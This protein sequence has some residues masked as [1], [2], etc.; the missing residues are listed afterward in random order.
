[1]A[2]RANIKI[3]LITAALL[4]G[5][6]V[7]TTP[8]DTIYVNADGTGDY[9]TIQAA[10]DA[11]T[12]GDEVVL[13]PGTYTGNGNRDLDFANALPEGQT[14]AITV[15][16]TD[17]NN[18]DVVE[19]TIINCEGTPNEPHRGFD[20]H[21]GE[22]AN[23]IISGLTITKGYS[24]EFGGGIKCVSSSPTIINCN[25]VANI[26]PDGG[27]GLSNHDSSPSLINCVFRENE[28]HWGGG[29]C[30]LGQS[31][32]TIANCT[33]SNNIGGD[34]AGVYDH[35]IGYCIL[36]NC[37]FN[38]NSGIG[39]Y[40]HGGSPK[41]TKCSFTNNS[42]TAIV[43][44]GGSPILSDCIFTDNQ[45]HGMYNYGGS[46]VLTSC[47]FIGNS[48]WR[49][50]GMYNTSH[51]SPLL[52][53][54]VFLGNSATHEGG[55]IYNYEST[56]ILNNCTFEDNSAEKGGGVY[57]G[58]HP[59]LTNCNFTNNSADEGGGMYGGYHPLLTNCNFAA[60]KAEYD[61]GGMYNHGGSPIFTN[62]L[63]TGNWAVETG[64][65]MCNV[66]SD[67]ILT[68]CTFVS[69]KAGE[70]GGL[71][72]WSSDPVL[73]NCIIAGNIDDSGTGETAQVSSY[74]YNCQPVIH[75]CCIT[76]WSHGGVGNIAADPLFLDPGYW[77]DNGT[78]DDIWDDVWYEGNYHIR[79]DSPCIDAGDPNFIDDPNLYDMDGEP[80]VIAGRVDIG[81][82]EHN[83]QIPYLTV[84]ST[85]L[86]YYSFIEE[87]G[88]SSQTL[89]L[90]NTGIGTLQWEIIGGSS[91][92]SI[93]N[94]SGTLVGDT[95]QDIFVSVDTTNLPVGDYTGSLVVRNLQVPYNQYQFQITLRV[96]HLLR[97]PEDYTT[98]QAAID[99]AEDGDTVLVANRTY[100]G[101]GNRD[102][103]FGGKLIILRS[104][105]GPQSCIIDC[106]GSADE[107]HRGFIFH[108][109]EDERATLEGFTITNG[110]ASYGG[111]VLCENANPTVTNCIFIENHSKYN[112]GGALYYE[113]WFHSIS[114]KSIILTNCTFKNNSAE[115]GGGICNYNGNIKLINCSFT[116]NFAGSGGGICHNGEGNMTLMNCIFSGNSAYDG[117]G[118]LSNGPGSSTLT[119]CIFKGNAA[120][121][122]GGGMD[123]YA[124]AILSN[125]L[126]TGNTAGY[127]GGGLSNY[128]GEYVTATN[129]TFVGNSLQESD[130][131]WWGWGAAG[132]ESIGHET[133]LT[134]CILWN[135]INRN[136]PVFE[137]QISNWGGWDSNINYCCIQGWDDLEWFLKGGVGNIGTEPN[138][139][140]PG[141]WDPNGTP[142]NYN[143]DEWIEGDYRLFPGSACI[144][145]GTDAGLYTD[146]EGN[147]RPLDG[148]NDG[149]ASADMGAYEALPADRALIMLSSKELEFF[150]DEGGEN[151]DA[152]TLAIW[153]GGPDI[154][155][156]TAIFDD[157]DWLEVNPA[158][159]SSTGQQNQITLSAGT[160]GMTW[161]QYNCQIEISDPCAMFSPVIVRVTLWVNIE[162]HVPA[163]FPT[164]QAAINAA[165]NGDRIIVADDVYTGDGNRDIDFRGK[166]ITLRSANGPAGCIINC[167]S[168]PSDPNHWYRG[169]NFHTAEGH[170]S[171]LDGFTIINGMAPQERI[172]EVIQIGLGQAITWYYVHRGGA[173]VC[174]RS[175]PTIHNCT[176]RGNGTESGGGGLHISSGSPR[177][178]NCRFAYNK[179][180]CGAGVYCTK[181]SPTLTNCHFINNVAQ[182][183][184]NIVEILQG[185]NVIQYTT[186]SCAGLYNSNST[187]T[188]ANCVFAGNVAMSP[189]VGGI[190]NQDST[191][192]I[193]N[194]T[195]VGNSG[196]YANT[197]GSEL[198]A[199]EFLGG[200]PSNI[201][202]ANSIL[203]DGVEEIYNDDGSTISI[204]YSDIDGGWPGE[205]NID[206]DPCFLDYGYWDDK[207]TPTDPNDDLWINGDYHLKWFSPCVNAGD[208]NRE[209]T[210]QTD[211]D[212]LQRVCLGR[213]DIGA[214]EVCAIAYWKMDEDAYDDIVR[215]SSGNYNNGTTQ[216]ITSV[217]H[218]E[219]IINGALTFNGID[220]YIQIADS[221]SLSPTQEVTVCGW[222]WFNDA[223]ENVGL[224]WKHNYNFALWTVS[225]TVRFA[226]WN[227]L[228]EGSTATFSTSLLETGW[229]FIAGVFDGT[230]SALYLNGAEAGTLG[231]SITGPIRDR[232]GDLYIGQRSDGVGNEYFAGLIDEAK[233][234]NRALPATEIAQLYNSAIS[235][236]PLDINL[237]TDNLWMYQDLPGQTASSL[238]VTASIAYDPLGNISYTYDWEIILPG[239]VT[240]PPTIINGGSAT[241]TFCTFAAPPC[242][243]PSSLSDSGQALTIRLTV[244]GDDYANSATAEAQF[245]IALLADVN[246]DTT[247]NVVDRSIIN[248]FWQN[249]SAED[250]TLRDCD[251]NCDGVVNVADRSIAN[252]IWRGA[253]G[254]NQ[255]TSPCPLR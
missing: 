34:G 251:V 178:K 180:S 186:A 237:Q 99:V 139:V 3:S 105:N 79:S 172:T 82:D 184:M 250:Y 171:V 148:D 195:F 74:Y 210:G 60:N 162:H 243:E 193:S 140:E 121:S 191:C 165:Q 159:G 239:D 104:E 75:Y 68:N 183:A 95:V 185:D 58:Y 132:I 137:A 187:S 190:F 59:I 45:G 145:A 119:N 166:A 87:G 155:N 92:F 197:L 47:T 175:S 10:I 135:N 158:F 111:G 207:G 130:Y 56:P 202:I 44:D 114:T 42:A 225:D 244:T 173:I 12:N 63:F 188:V 167:G 18:P 248:A 127:S 227:S 100:R 198:Y 20:F 181:S 228:S 169:F 253:L 86:E 144:D 216:Q 209:Y 96:R 39:L 199:K 157:C 6:N 150:T 234:Y 72:N 152:Q 192:T 41:L 124:T 200:S 177:I 71:R 160:E 40:S 123:N 117:G 23:S 91:W 133:T 81:A 80:R 32:P 131:P 2:G 98:I 5:G 212:G 33:F 241:D 107:R 28:G 249:G 4:L 151:P 156:W 110:Y 255:V 213:V 50:G 115:Y 25:F 113:Y 69:N 174:D 89:Q 9:P 222:F 109:N 170:D 235:Q 26:A 49:G 126:F 242:D 67:P 76:G 108:N 214:D 101:D 73:T 27:G 29:I 35:G 129:C 232:A 38:T 112:S 36:I 226:V 215:D 83:S 134:N 65:G 201:T 189:G 120:E 22:D 21:S 19:A 223:S 136:G 203:W 125:C 254:Q 204:T 208:P 163:D 17:P 14:R 168:I 30:N 31:N 142:F 147:L 94:T 11:A 205:G 221:E 102:I 97:V 15:R 164:I 143:D 229:N 84:S 61:G 194:C 77:D 128:W 146:I 153:N 176:I 51:S 46:P 238:T 122:D 138:F 217:L 179:A 43:S 55:G 7:A 48:S 64:G 182:G 245:G 62:C 196:S 246:N 16:S 154:L 219:G 149:T 116:S 103:D 90:R 93:D 220:D 230:N 236:I 233:I 206:T 66:Q 24:D 224:I 78:P 70:G 13:A 52:T 218:A 1:M 54:C 141:W 252:A 37:T 161:G 247:V 85:W 240:M 118:V 106:Q 53:G 57:G 8:A 211:M 231:A 88:I